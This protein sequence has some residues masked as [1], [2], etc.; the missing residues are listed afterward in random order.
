[1]PKLRVD[2][3]GY[4]LVG[5]AKIC[6]ITSAGIEVLARGRNGEKLF[7]LLTRTDVESIFAEFDTK[8]LQSENPCSIMSNE[9]TK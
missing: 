7:V 3:K 1:M 5:K 2:E 9:G 6:R 4:V 8:L